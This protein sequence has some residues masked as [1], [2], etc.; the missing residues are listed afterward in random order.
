M[1]QAAVVVVTRELG[2]E[3]SREVQRLRRSSEST[4]DVVGLL[5]HAHLVALHLVHSLVL[6]LLSVVGREGLFLDVGVVVD[7]A[8]WSTAIL[9]GAHVGSRGVVTEAEVEVEI[10]IEVA[11]L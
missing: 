7:V 11:R 9:K 6:D 10:E 4:L 1:E 5:C 3:R 8:C 2:L